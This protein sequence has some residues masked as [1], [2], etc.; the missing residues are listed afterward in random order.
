MR[1]FEHFSSSEVWE[2][3]KLN[4]IASEELASYLKVQVISAQ[5]L[6]KRE[7]ARS[8]PHPASG[9]ELQL[10]SR[11]LDRLHGTGSKYGTWP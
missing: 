4:R 9:A 10:L 3:S 11:R 7:Q 1:S 2:H 6:S 5:L 8:M